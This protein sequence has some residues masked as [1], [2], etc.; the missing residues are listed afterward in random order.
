MSSGDP[1]PLTTLVQRRGDVLGAI[2][3]EPLAKQDLD[4]RLDVSRSTIDRA[5]EELLEAGLVEAAD[6][7]Y[8]QT[9]AGRLALAEH[10][11][12]RR[13][14]EGVV[15]AA[16]LL[17]TLEDDA[18]L[19]TELLAGARVLEA[20][21]NATDRPIEALYDVV[22]RA[23]F[24]RG[25][26]VAIHSRQVDTY[27]RRFVEEGLGGEVVLTA[28]AIEQL[29]GR[30]PEGFQDALATDRVAFWETD[31]TFPYSLTLAETPDGPHVGV[32]VYDGEDVPGCLIND[33][34]AA[35]EWARE[36]FESVRERARPVGGDGGPTA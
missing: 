19:G 1:A 18:G 26:G 34:R 5:V 2:E 35:V 31:E 7:G 22:E 14:V 20:T 13:G 28:S 6:G 9:L 30:Y 21:P 3:E 29:L 4:R 36:R 17:D 16:D 11:R 23:S 15:D 25:F 24:V 10:D 12:L 32:V 8:R 27:H 33:T